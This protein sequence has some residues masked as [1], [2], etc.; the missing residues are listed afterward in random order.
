MLADNATA[1]RLYERHGFE[2]E[3]RLRRYVR[4]GG[5]YADAYVMAAL[6]E[7]GPLA[8]RC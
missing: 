4:R 7:P 2:I 3:G 6:F 1:I 5:A 8:P